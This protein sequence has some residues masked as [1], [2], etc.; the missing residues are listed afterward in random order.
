MY[1]SYSTNFN[2]TEWLSQDKIYYLLSEM[3]FSLYRQSLLYHTVHKKK[4]SVTTR[5]YVAVKMRTEPTWAYI[6][7]LNNTEVDRY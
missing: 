6:M 4:S 7:I 1:C 5:S 2:F 3:S